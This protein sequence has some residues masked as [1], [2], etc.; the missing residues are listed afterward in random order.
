VYELVIPLQI[1]RPSGSATPGNAVLGDRGQGSISDKTAAGIGSVCKDETPP[2]KGL[3]SPGKNGAIASG[4]SPGANNVR[5]PSR[6]GGSSMD[7]SAD[8]RRNRRSG[9]GA[10]THVFHGAIEV[11]FGKRTAF[12]DSGIG[13]AK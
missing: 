5:A 9:R 8:S 12:A 13:I 6:E 3:S 10:S 11:G 1:D 2:L 4:I 7:I